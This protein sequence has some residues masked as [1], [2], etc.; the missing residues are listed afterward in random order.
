MKTQPPVPLVRKTCN[1]CGGKRYTD[2]MTVEE[3]AVYAAAWKCHDCN[4]R[5]LED[6]REAA[7]DNP[8]SDR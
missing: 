8:I 5:T 4:V 7:G 3:Q 1:V 6:W 2:S